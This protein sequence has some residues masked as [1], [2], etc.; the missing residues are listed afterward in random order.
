MSIP[1]IASLEIGSHRTVVLV[2]EADA[3]GRM[4][5]VGKGV[6]ISSGVHKGQ[7]ID[8]SHADRKSVV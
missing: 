1:P 8:F 6:N 3:D 5:V 2:G 4:T 7:V